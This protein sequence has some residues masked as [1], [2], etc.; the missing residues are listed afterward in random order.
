MATVVG[1][2]TMLGRRVE[3]GPTGLRFRTLLR[4]HR[5]EWDAI[6]SFEDV[7]VEA[8][9]PRLHSTNLRVAARLRGGAVAWLPVPHVGAAEV[10][11]F[12]EQ[13]AQLR[14]LRRRYSRDTSV[15]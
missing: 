8:G 7:R 2:L 13:V 5:L 10:R 11:S 6:V 9:D 14:A 15:Q 12:E 1:A 3:A 4:W